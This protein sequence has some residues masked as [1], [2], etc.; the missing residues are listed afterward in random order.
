MMKSKVCF[1]ALLLVT[2]ITTTSCKGNLPMTNDNT[3]PDFSMYTDAQ[4][5]I[6]NQIKMALML[7]SDGEIIDIA[8]IVKFDWAKVYVFGENTSYKAI[9][10]ALGINWLPNKSFY[11]DE[12]TDLLVFVKDQQVVEYVIVRGDIFVAMNKNEYLREESKFKVKEIDDANRPK[13]LIP[14]QTP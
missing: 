10:T 13:I 7:H 11:I 6:E 5:E 1:L 9:N 4:T 3:Q 12:L 2:V 14:Y 8:E